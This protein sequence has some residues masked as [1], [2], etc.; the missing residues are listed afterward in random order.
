ME[1]V[2]FDWNDYLSSEGLSDIV[3]AG[4]GM[5][6]DQMGQAGPPV[7]E[8]SSLNDHLAS[9]TLQA[10]DT[11]EWSSTPMHPWHSQ[12]LAGHHSFQDTAATLE[13]DVYGSPSSE[14][15][16]VP[17]PPVTLN[18]DTIATQVQ[19][20][21]HGN[22]NSLE[23]SE[24]RF[25]PFP[26]QEAPG[27]SVSLTETGRDASTQNSN[28]LKAL[29]PDQVCTCAA[30]LASSRCPQHLRGLDGHPERLSWTFGCPVTG[31][32]WKTKDDARMRFYDF[33]D[34]QELYF[35]QRE[36]RG[37]GDHYGRPGEYKCR[38]P[39]CNSVTKRWSDFMR[40]SSKHCIKPQ[41][42]ECPVLDCKYHHIGFPRKDKLKSH[43]QN[44][45]AGRLQPGK[46]NQA[47]KPKADGSA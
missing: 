6:G 3:P 31:C 37:R 41:K 4:L 24:A 8:L 40:H 28:E 9:Q 47:I 10:A 19:D 25:N 15:L 44:V 11:G 7:L 42:F 27:F 16:E 45:H 23:T 36:R 18:Y 30:C 5:H 14:L 34:L 12:Q 22:M 21:H 39:G 35:H 43:Y 17:P 26:P 33:N 13:H 1:G 29:V 20:Q 2:P 32:Q 46:P 38:E